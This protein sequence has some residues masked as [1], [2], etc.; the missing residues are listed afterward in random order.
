MCYYPY[1]LLGR[2]T[3]F[4]AILTQTQSISL[5]KEAFFGL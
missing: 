1:I 4:E 5:Y 2:K 3:D